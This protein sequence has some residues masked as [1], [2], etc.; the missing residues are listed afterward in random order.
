MLISYFSRWMDKMSS[1]E[2]LVPNT[3]AGRFDCINRTFTAQDVEKL[4]GSVPFDYTLARRG[5]LKLW[6][7]LKTEPYINALGAL[8]GNQAMQM[9][10]AG[11]TAIYLSGWQVAA[12][13]HPPGALY[14]DQSPYPAKAGPELARLIHRTPQRANQKI[15]TPH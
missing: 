13:A 15:R 6:E 7:L 10:R 8:S 4:R 2:T 1:F 3:P 14:R 12:D 11:L 9:L 5:A